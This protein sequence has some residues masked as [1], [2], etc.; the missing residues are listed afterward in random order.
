MILPCTCKHPFQDQTYGKG[1]RVHNMM[2][3][4]GKLSAKARCTVC[5]TVHDIGHIPVVKD[6]K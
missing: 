6:K 4:D 1:Q 3:K 2:Q 5:K